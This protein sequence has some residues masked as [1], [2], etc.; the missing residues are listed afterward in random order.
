M[1]Y[2][3]A[4]DEVQDAV[5]TEY[6]KVRRLKKSKQTTSMATY[7]ARPCQDALAISAFC[8]VSLDATNGC[9]PHSRKT[10]LSADK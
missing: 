5:V 2:P 10:K 6:K 3:A 8:C 4:D 7:L 9:E 1:A